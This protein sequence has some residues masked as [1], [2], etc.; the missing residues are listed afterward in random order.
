MKM[1]SAA[2]AIVA[3]WLGLMSISA[4]AAQA[5]PS[6]EQAVPAITSGYGSDGHYDV[7]QQSVPNPAFSRADVQ[8]FF[9]QGA[10][11]PRPVIFFSH[12]YGPNIWE[13]YSVLFHHWVS[14]GNIVVYSTYPMAFADNDGR[15]DDLWAGFAAAA[16][17]YGSRMD[18]SRVG[19]AGHSYGGGASPAMAARALRQGW[20]KKGMFV[21][22]LAPWYT[23]QLTREQERQMPAS[24]PQLFEIYEDD[25][26]ND[27]RMAVDL[28]NNTPDSSRYFF[29]VH[30]MKI[31]DCNLI[32]DHSIPGRSGV[33]RIKQYGMF[34]PLDAIADLAFAQS[35]EA[36]DALNAMG[37]STAGGAFNPLERV[38]QP[39]P[40]HDESAY[41]F[42]WSTPKNPRL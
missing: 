38:T 12:G 31:G 33:L 2:L 15:Y 23:F 29:L 9:P 36:G 22:A 17:R 8:V 18:L 7:E 25:T 1:N 11:G 26:T 24:V 21:A 42:R 4:M 35:K 10:D 6:C 19:F 28:Y 30:S 34:R 39:K 16:D 14:R 13:A 41:H 3:A 20:G 40:L 27:H 5:E 32:A 37:S